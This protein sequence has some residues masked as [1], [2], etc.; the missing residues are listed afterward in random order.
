M[1]I[2]PLRRKNLGEILLAWGLIKEEQIPVALEEQKR[3]KENFGHILVKLGYA[4]EEDVLKAVAF[5]KGL[6]YKVVSKIKL[7]EELRDVIPEDM[8]RLFNIIPISKS[9]SS[10]TVAMADPTNILIIEEIEKK[11]G[12][13]VT[14][15]L[16]SEEDILKV[17][18]RFYVGFGG[19]KSLTSELI[20][21]ID[22]EEEEEEEEYDITAAPIVKYVDSVIRESIAKMASDIHLEPLENKTSLRFRIDGKLKDFPGPAQKAY[23]AI[24]SRIK[25]MANLDIAERRLPQDGKCRIRLGDKQVDARIST[26]PTIH[27]EKLVMRLLTKM[28]VTLEVDALGFS[29]DAALKYKESLRNPHGMILVTGPTGSGKTTTLYA[30]INHINEP[31]KNIV[32]IEDPVEYQLAQINQIQ[33]RPAINLTFANILKTVLRQDPDV[34]MVGEVRD[35]ET[36]ELAVQAA[37]TGHLVL[38]TLHTNDAVGT[39]S[40]LKYVGIEP[41]LIADAVNLVIAQRLVRKICPDCKEEH[42]VPIE[43]LEKLN[44]TE[45]KDLKLYHGKGCEMC[46][47]SGYKGR[48]AVYEVLKLTT[49]IK[50]MIL[51]GV[52]DI[53]IKERAVEEG[54]HP[55]GEMAIEKLLAGMTTVEEVLAVT[56][57]CRGQTLYQN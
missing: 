47:G 29:D 51:T 11:T 46:L 6:E 42:K 19:V 28:D 34:I 44:L 4:Q 39:L 48:T 32:T 5:Q 54:L 26:M 2:E 40:R 9:E 8:A 56:F 22:E 24:I 53:E 52:N 21:T 45:K 36:A 1:V 13:K 31:D 57:Y 16:D 18:D 50:R 7:D 49:E 30:G 27:G 55:L 12:L 10:V 38:S 20:E 15:V 14:P 25:I 33:V 23:P 35:K 37:L 41:Y 43:I 3:T 17:I